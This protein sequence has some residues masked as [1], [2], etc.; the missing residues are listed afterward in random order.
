MAISSFKGGISLI[1]FS[2][3]HLVIGTD[4]VQLGELFGSI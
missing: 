3:S 2:Y 1:V 4:Q